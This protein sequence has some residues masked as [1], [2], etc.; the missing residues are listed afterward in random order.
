MAF[1]Q[2]YTN[3]TTNNFATLTGD[4]SAQAIVVSLTAGAP[5]PHLPTQT[6]PNSTSHPNSLFIGCGLNYMRIKMLTSG[7]A[8]LAGGAPTF[9]V[10]GWSKDART[11]IW[12]ARRICALTASAAACATTNSVNIGNI[13]ALREVFDYGTAVSA[14]DAKIYAGTVNGGGFFLIDTIGTEFLEIHTTQATG[15]DSFSAL[16]GSL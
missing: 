10:Y 2:I 1:T 7:A 3:T 11:G 16:C 14:G 6:K 15:G 12:D 4:P 9:H 8:T 13:G 5:G